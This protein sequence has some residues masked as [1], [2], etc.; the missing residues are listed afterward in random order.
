MQFAHMA[1]GSN[2]RLEALR[3]ERNIPLKRLAAVV[4]RDQ[5]TYWRYEQG[6]T[7]IGWEQ[8]VALASFYGVTTD[9]LMGRDLDL[10]PAA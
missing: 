2:N 7:P 8:I 1:S 3:R 4:D 10:E 5:S 9:Y 6:T